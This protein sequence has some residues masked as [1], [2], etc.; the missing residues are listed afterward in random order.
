MV[1]IKSLSHLLHRKIYNIDPWLKNLNQV[2]KKKI[3]VEINLDARGSMCQK[4]IGRMVLFSRRGENQPLLYLSFICDQIK[5]YYSINMFS[6]NW[7]NAKNK[8]VSK[9]FKIASSQ[10]RFGFL[11][12]VS[13]QIADCHLTKFYIF[14]KWIIWPTH[15]FPLYVRLLGKVKGKVSLGKVKG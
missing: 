1:M 2:L 12:N 15:F 14:T 9:H 3:C 8:I 11:Q 4:T 6:L 5:N 10:L 7:L 13:G